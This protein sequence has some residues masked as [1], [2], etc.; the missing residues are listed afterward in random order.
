MNQRNIYVANR[1]TQAMRELPRDHFI[2]MSDP[3]L[4]VGRIIPPT[5]AISE[6]LQHA[7]IMPEHNVLLIGTGAGYMAALASKLASQVVALEVDS[8]LA[9]Q[10]QLRFNELGLCNLVQRTCDGTTGAADLG[11]YDR[12][13]VSTAKVD[14]KSALIAQLADGG[15]LLALEDAEVDSQILTRYEISELGATL[16][17]ELA[18]VDFSRDAGMTLLDMGMVDQVML[19][20]AR[21]I[22]RDNKLPV[23]KVLRDKLNME[24]ATLYKRLAEEKAM[25]FAVIDDLLKQ[26]QPELM[27]GF[28]RSFLDS[29]HLIPLKAEGHDLQVV[30]DDPDSSIGDIFHMY[31]YQGVQKILVTPNDFKRLWTTVEL[32]LQGNAQQLWTAQAEVKE[33]QRDLLDGDKNKV[34][35]HLITLCDALLVD[36]VSEGAS[37]LHIEQYKH[38]V[39]IR[40]RVDGDLHD[41]SSI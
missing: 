12:I 2:E 21:R 13:L 4:L 3:A 1:V 24:D 27:E 9:H 5:N 37:D 16:R 25:P 30:T 29:H 14:D 11:P 32:S 23:I 34:E 20:Q 15:R 40:L 7:A 6:I 22:A 39:R 31:P 17:R 28:S 38:R 41:L 19:S 36:A 33:E 26:V 8:T 35:A 18:M 10:A